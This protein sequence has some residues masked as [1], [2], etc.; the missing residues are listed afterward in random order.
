MCLELYK[1]PFFFSCLKSGYL[2]R[3]ENDETQWAQVPN[4]EN[5]RTAQC[6]FPR[7]TW[8]GI[9]LF[10][11]RASRGNRTSAW[12]EDKEFDTESQGEP[13]VPPWGGGALGALRAPQPSLRPALTPRARVFQPS[14]PRPP[15]S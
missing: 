1:K 9:Y 13:A 7:S 4:C 11:V 8:R 12:S 10:R 3:T 14:C 15:W 5:V 2:K 6:V